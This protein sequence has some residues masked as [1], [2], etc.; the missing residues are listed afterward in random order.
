VI[1]CCGLIAA[2]KSRTERAKKL[3]VQIVP[4]GALALCAHQPIARLAVLMCQ[5]SRLSVKMRISAHRGRHFRL[6][7]D[8]I[9]A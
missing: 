8:A 6:N 3:G 9:S 5:S 4:G 2:G 7:V 1:V